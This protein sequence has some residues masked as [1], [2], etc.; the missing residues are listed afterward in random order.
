MK[1]MP[2]IVA[3]VDTKNLARDIALTGPLPL[4]T[5]LDNLGVPREGRVFDK[6]GDGIPGDGILSKL[7]YL[8]GVMGEDR[9]VDERGT[10]YPGEGRMSKCA[11]NDANY[12]MKAFLA[13]V[14][15][16]RRASPAFDPVT[17]SD[18]CCL[19]CL[20]YA[21]Y[22]PVPD[23][24]RTEAEEDWAKNLDEENSVAPVDNVVLAS[25]SPETDDIPDRSLSPSA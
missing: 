1:D 13:F 19:E 9:V 15:K 24:K 10:G 5:L 16:R 3:T 12:K 11:G 20:E 18:G 17:A 6:R 8:L 22:Q 4:A 25:S 23:V 21:V 7:L 14:T 2:Q